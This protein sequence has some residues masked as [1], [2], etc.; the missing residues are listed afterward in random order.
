MDDN[1]I[2][3]SL[4]ADLNFY[5][6]KVQVKQRKDQVNIL[7]TRGASN[8]IDYEV[9]YDVVRSGLEQL[10]D[11]PEDVSKFVVYGRVAGSRQPEWQKSGE[12]DRQVLEDLEAADLLLG[13]APSSS[14]DDDDTLGQALKVPPIPPTVTG[15]SSGL[16]D[17][18]AMVESVKADALEA[19]QAE[20]MSAAEMSDLGNLDQTSD[21]DLEYED[22]DDADED[23]YDDEP[24]TFIPG[25]MPFDLPTD[26]SD[27]HNADNNGT[28]IESDESELE[29]DVSAD[30]SEP[31][32]QELGN[33]GGLSDLESI[34]SLDV[35]DV[36]ADFADLSEALDNGI[37]NVTE[38]PD[39]GDIRD[40]ADL[41]GT[42]DLDDITEAVIADEV[43]RDRNRSRSKRGNT[44]G[45]DFYDDY[46]MQQQI[47]GERSP[48]E[49]AQD[50][51]SV[52]LFIPEE[53]ENSL[54]IPNYRDR[55]PEEI[56]VNQPGRS[57]GENARG[58]T[59][60]AV[61]I[62]LIAVA[63][64]AW[65]IDSSTQERRLT[66]AKSISDNVLP[67][68]DIGKLDALQQNNQNL[69]SAIARLEKIPNR[70]SSSTSYREARTELAKLRE[71]QTAFKQKLTIEETA[72]N[73]LAEAKKLA[74]EAATMTQNPPHPTEVWEEAQGKWQQ[75]VDLLKKVPDGTL[76]TDEARSKL[77]GYEKNYTVVTAL[78]QKQRAFDLAATYWP[79]R[80]GADNQ[81]YFRQLKA[82]GT[83]Q[84][85]FVSRCAGSVQPGLSATELQTEG[86]QVRTFSVY[87]CQYIWEQI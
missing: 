5:R 29:F 86:Y 79:D 42:E 21:A 66:E 84:P 34:G 39:I 63:G 28:A 57:R 20:Q 83:Q 55:P 17:L 10:G 23:D 19:E 60:A 81:S 71:K 36:E 16:E 70:P 27:R 65:V 75:A 59:V 69:N 64:A 9:L 52:D 53:P 87:L 51:E 26:I 33:L 25:S 48:S 24:A 58:L 18:A 74:Y 37:G 54:E 49:V 2:T 40:T 13:N 22:T 82:T 67:V 80:I 76:S 4:Q 1:Q 6:V 56:T 12:I 62:A 3:K 45:E 73:Q 46:Y 14:P 31:T 15:R 30:R 32:E 11:L 38:I 44:S 41:P 77:E 50:P 8:D 47:G 7:V 43:R 72:A 85:E 61:L 78:A 68:E 35:D